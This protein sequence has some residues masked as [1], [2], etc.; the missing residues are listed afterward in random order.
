ML[1]EQETGAT[2]AE[3]CRRHGISE[4]AFYCWKSGNTVMRRGLSRLTDIALEATVGAEICGQL[5]AGEGRLARIV[6]QVRD[7]SCDLKLT[8][9]QD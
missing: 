6:G 2:T 8:V 3:V 9:T 4:Q 1:R 7:A 5:K